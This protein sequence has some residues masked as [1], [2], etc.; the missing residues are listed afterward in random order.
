MSPRHV[1][2]ELA[3]LNPGR[4]FYCDQRAYCVG[5][6]EDGRIIPVLRQTLFCSWEP[7]DGILDQRRYAWQPVEG[8][9]GEQWQASGSP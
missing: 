2:Q 8:S 1:A 6:A 3:R 4:Q 9:V 7:W 5:T